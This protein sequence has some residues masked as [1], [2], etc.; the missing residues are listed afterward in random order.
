MQ[1]Y[2][3]WCKYKNLLCSRPCMVLHFLELRVVECKV[4]ERHFVEKQET[5]IMMKRHFVELINS[6]KA[7]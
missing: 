2:S 4:V 7:K 5:D 1:P 6:G 3:P